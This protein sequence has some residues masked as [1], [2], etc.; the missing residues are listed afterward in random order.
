[1]VAW[2]GNE[3][4]S[5]AFFS[6]VLEK[7]VHDSLMVTIEG[8]KMV[9]EEFGEQVDTI[10]LWSDPGP[11]YRPYLFVSSLVTYITEQ[12]DRHINISWT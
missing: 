3:E 6:R 8:I 10:H 1:M 12:L 11:H 5:L 7:S 4:R 2:S 9:L